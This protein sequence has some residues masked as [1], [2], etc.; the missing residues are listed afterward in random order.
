MID[1]MT[2]MIDLPPHWM[3]LTDFE[4]FYE[5]ICLMTNKIINKSHCRTQ[6]MRELS[7]QAFLAH[8]LIK[9]LKSNACD[10]DQVTIKWWQQFTYIANFEEKKIKLMKL[11]FWRGEVSICWPGAL[12]KYVQRKFFSHNFL[13]CLSRRRVRNQDYK[14]NPT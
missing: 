9:C 2:F 13:S 5:N 6:S 4:V 10:T 7:T 1:V 3:H 12:R 14:Q 11:P 8:L